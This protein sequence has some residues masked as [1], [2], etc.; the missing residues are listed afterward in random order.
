MEEVNEDKRSMLKEDVHAPGAGEGTAEA[1]PVKISHIRYGRLAQ[2][3]ILAVPTD[4]IPSLCFAVEAATG[5]TLGRGKKVP[6]LVRH[7]TAR[8]VTTPGPN[9]TLST[10]THASHRSR[11]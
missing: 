7:V 11:P 6:Y 9:L 1:K 3:L 8:D 10:P 5:E 4:R 2:D